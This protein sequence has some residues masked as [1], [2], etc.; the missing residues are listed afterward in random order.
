MRYFYIICLALSSIFTYKHLIAQEQI[1]QYA[2]FMPNNAF[3]QNTAV[4]DIEKHQFKRHSEED[5]K[6]EKIKPQITLP[7]VRKKVKSAPPKNKQ[8]QSEVVYEKPK[9][10]E[11]EPMQTSQ[12]IIDNPE[13]GLAPSMQKRLMQYSLDEQLSEEEMS[14]QPEDISTSSQKADYT[15]L[16]VE[17]MFKNISFPDES[18]PKYKQAYANYGMDLRILYR[19]G[20]LPDN[21]EQDEA[22]AKANTIQRF[23]VE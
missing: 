19:H 1:K 17:E 18:L 8:Q 6:T 22:L 10:E 2:F 15:Q 4:D 11:L 5:F 9:I 21:R 20:K 7:Y 13:G 3:L 14:K 16:S 23:K 12:Q